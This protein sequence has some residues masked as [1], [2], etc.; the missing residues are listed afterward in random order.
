MTATAPRQPRQWSRA[1]AGVAVL[2]G[3]GEGIG[4]AIAVKLAELGHDVAILDINP[5]VAPTAAEISDRFGVRAAFF[6]CDI[7]EVRDVEFAFASVRDELGAP[8][9]LV[10]NAGW[11]PFAKFLQ[12]TVEEEERVIEVNL[13]GFMRLCR[14][15]LPGMVEARW[16]RVVIVSSDAARIGMPGE[17]VYS[18]AKAGLVGFGKAL[19]AELA[20]SDVTVNIV[21]PGST[22]S[23][24]LRGLFD[25]E[26]IDKRKRANPMRRLAAPEDIANAVGFF[27]HEASGYVTGQVLSVNGGALRIG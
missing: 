7:G 3:G 5:G 9:A 15:V 16:G 21:S 1:A 24:M 22:D 11:T 2:A 26:Q 13:R 8:T 6:P 4:T 19:A 25:E 18:G 12:I 10:H 17:S 20:Q 14:E 27:V 23:P